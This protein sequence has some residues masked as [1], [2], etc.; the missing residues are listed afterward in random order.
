MTIIAPGNA[1]LNYDPFDELRE[2]LDIDLVV[3]QRSSTPCSL[4]L[5]AQSL[6]PGVYRE[7]RGPVRPVR[8]ELRL[9]QQLLQN[10]LT[11]PV[12]V[13]GPIAGAVETVLSDCALSFRRACCC[14]R[15]NT[16]MW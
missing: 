15:G 12:A 7:M 1:V 14:L 6:M 4:A 3:R 11:S 10:D 16:R 2:T 9:G 13:T 8:Y 5:A